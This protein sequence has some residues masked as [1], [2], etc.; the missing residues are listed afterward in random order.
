MTYSPRIEI[1]NAFN[2][3]KNEAVMIIEAQPGIASP[4]IILCHSTNATDPA[5]TQA[6]IAAMM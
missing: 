3:P 4:V 2:A 5:Q 6:D 1:P